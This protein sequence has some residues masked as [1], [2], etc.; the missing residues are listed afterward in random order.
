[1]SKSFEEQEKREQKRQET[2]YNAYRAADRI[3]CDGS[4]GSEEETNYLTAQ[5]AEKMMLR[6]LLPL[7]TAML[8]KDLED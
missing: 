8:K 7:R 1:M 6:G 5:V 3:I 2:I 4:D